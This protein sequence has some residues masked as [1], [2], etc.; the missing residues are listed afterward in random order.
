MTDGV[1]PTFRQLMEY[2]EEEK[3]RRR[4]ASRVARWLR[5]LLCGV[6]EWLCGGLRRLWRRLERVKQL[7]EEMKGQDDG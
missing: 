7:I 5:S 4:L 2:Y 6:K 1:D 3:N